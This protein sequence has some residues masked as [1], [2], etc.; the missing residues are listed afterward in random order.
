[1]NFDASITHR[2]YLGAAEK[3]F[4]FAARFGATVYMSLVL[5]K[6]RPYTALTLCF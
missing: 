6:A 4:I 5:S 1:M 3:D 2:E